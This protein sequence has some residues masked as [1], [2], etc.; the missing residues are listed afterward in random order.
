MP[1]LH[2]PLNTCHKKSFLVSGA[3]SGLFTGSLSATSVAF[4][5]VA[6]PTNMLACGPC[7][8]CKTL[9]FC[10]LV[11]Q[12]PLPA[13]VLHFLVQQ[14]KL[15]K[16]ASTAIALDIYS[17][18]NLPLLQAEEPLRW[19]AGCFCHVRGISEVGPSSKHVSMWHT[20]THTLPQSDF[21]KM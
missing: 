8:T 13:A 15:K 14:S 2:V 18:R 20:H 6:L 10:A 9:S 7:P 21:L 3:L 5:R 11:S 4:Q 1:A 17:I 16:H 12:A 19:I